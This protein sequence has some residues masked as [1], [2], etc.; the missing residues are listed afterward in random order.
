MAVRSDVS[1][2]YI[3]LGAWAYAVRRSSIVISS[4]IRAREGAFPVEPPVG[5]AN[6]EEIWCR[7]EERKDTALVAFPM[8]GI[9]QSHKHQAYFS[10]PGSTR[11]HAV[12]KPLV[13]L[14]HIGMIAAGNTIPLNACCISYIERRTTGKW[15]CIL[16]PTF[17]GLFLQPN[18]N[19]N[20]Q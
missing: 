16:A 7:S 11:D 19:N 8:T 12:R 6:R 2:Y 3:R 1:G 17:G 10:W 14:P 13:D 5:V 15:D 20:W 4:A 9:C 18:N